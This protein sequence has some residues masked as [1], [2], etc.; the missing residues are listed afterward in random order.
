M[1]ILD[2]N[3][4]LQNILYTYDLHHY[5][6]KPFSSPSH[7][8]I[9]TPCPNPTRGKKEKKKDKKTLVKVAS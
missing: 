5:Y 4:K 2:Y 1:A 3:P 9:N 7:Q 8:N 6:Y